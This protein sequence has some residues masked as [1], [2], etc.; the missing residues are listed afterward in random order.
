MKE[1]PATKPTKKPRQPQRITMPRLANAIYE[2]VGVTEL[3]MQST[4]DDLLAALQTAYFK[5]ARG[6]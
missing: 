1:T 6:Q 4:I 5:D 2:V 3:T